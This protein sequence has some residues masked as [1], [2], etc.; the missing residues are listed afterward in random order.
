MERAP[1]EKGAEV[2]RAEKDERSGKRVWDVTRGVAQGVVV[3]SGVDWVR[4][5]R[6]RQ[7][8]VGCGEE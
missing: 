5:K 3:G 6:W 8:V 2:R 1:A 7:L 4:D